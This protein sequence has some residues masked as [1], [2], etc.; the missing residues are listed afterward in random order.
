MLNITFWEL[1]RVLLKALAAYNESLFYYNELSSYREN[2]ER[3][4][5]KSKR[6]E[7]LWHHYHDIAGTYCDALAVMTCKTKGH[8]FNI[9]TEATNKADLYEPNWMR[10]FCESV[11][12]TIF[13]R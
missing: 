7:E 4:T 2:H 10:D 6:L 1:R 9:L 3:A 11:P 5:K 8:F 13:E 12:T